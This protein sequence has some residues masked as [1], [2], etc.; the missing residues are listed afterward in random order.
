M[1]RKVFRRLG[2]EVTGELIQKM[3]Q[4]KPW[5]A[6][7]FLLLLQQR[8]DVPPNRVNA[9]DRGLCNLKAIIVINPINKQNNDLEYDSKWDPGSITPEKF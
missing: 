1:C 3:V 5:C 9:V 8:L 4:C 6:E 7:Q 2:F